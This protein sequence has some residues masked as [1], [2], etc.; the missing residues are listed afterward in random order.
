MMGLL[1]TVVV[2]SAL[3]GAVVWLFVLAARPGQRLAAT[4]L[5]P[6]AR[7]TVARVW[8]YAVLWVPFVV[9]GA[10]L[11][12]GLWALAAQ[13]FDHCLAHGG[14]HGHHLCVVHPPHAASEPA[15]WVV[16]SALVALC[17]G[18]A[19][20]FA[21]RVFREVRLAR[22][23]VLLSQPT[24]WG[25]DVRL[26]DGPEPVACTVGDGRATILLSKGLVDKLTPKQLHIVLTHE[27]AHVQR[28]DVLSS[29]AD[30][31]VCSLLP[32]WVSRTLMSQIVLAREQVCDEASAR[33]VGSKLDVAATILAV[34]RLG[35]HRPC[36]GHCFADGELEARIH[37]LLTPAATT[38][39]WLMGVFGTVTAIVLLGAGPLHVAIEA[40]TT[41]ILH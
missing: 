14:L 1:Q 9:L 19:G 24:E 8:L 31:F 13:Q 34:A 11:M 10:A 21:A 23:L 18:F 32:A 20:L 27:R 7:Q 25:N 41:A 30:R 40:L 17:A 2:S 22:A 29:L 39:R 16:A 5:T 3:I 37:H 33:E 15:T 38:R 35:V 4:S 26:L 6:F 36:A 12:P 28:M